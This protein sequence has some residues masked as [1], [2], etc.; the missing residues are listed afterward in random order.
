MATVLNAFQFLA[1]ALAIACASAS[2]EG[3][4]D[5]VGEGRAY[6]PD[7]QQLIERLDHDDPAI[8][9]EA[10][11]AIAALGTRAFTALER[12]HLHPS[13][14]VRARAA[15]LLYQNEEYVFRCF[16]RHPDFP[17]IR[18]LWDGL[19]DTAILKRQIPKP[20]WNSY[21][22]R[23][24]RTA[25][26]D[27][28][29][30][31]DAL[32]VRRLSSAPRSPS[33][34]LRLL[35]ETGATAL[36]LLAGRYGVAGEVPEMIMKSQWVRSGLPKDLVP[37]LLAQE[38]DPAT[39]DEVY[40]IL[41]QRD[42]GLGGLISE[43][44]R[45]DGNVVLRL[46]VHLRRR[47]MDAPMSMPLTTEEALKQV[48]NG[49]WMQGMAEG[50][51][52]ASTHI[53]NPD[54]SRDPLEIVCYFAAERYPAK[55]PSEQAYEALRWLDVV[56]G[57][58]YFR[59]RLQRPAQPQLPPKYRTEPPSGSEELFGG[60]RNL[61]AGK[62]DELDVALALVPYKVERF[63]AVGD[64]QCLIALMAHLAE[65]IVEEVKSSNPD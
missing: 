33:E 64:R 22:G 43:L 4:Q 8:R 42:I 51:G 24:R 36:N 37:R 29:L 26:Y 49:P 31:L 14:E 15:D 40:G 53:R 41:T 45:T 9:S 21:N 44:S 34:V 10:G 27:R 57:R 47:P 28:A 3:A 58:E 62:G 16:L 2:L 48:L 63:W 32:P 55:G 30:L 25:R 50:I 59:M 6:K 17:E 7:I 38:P 46:L 23:G 11:A 52:R 35:R 18:R 19:I 1:V 60:V 20:L 56:L 65:L 54:K 13:P 5:P 12:A 39:F 61:L